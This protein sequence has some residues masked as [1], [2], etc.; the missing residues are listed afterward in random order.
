LVVATASFLLV[1]GPESVRLTSLWAR[2]LLSIVFGSFQ[3]LPLLHCMHDASHTS[4][5]PSSGWWRFLGRLTM[6]FF[7][8]ASLTSWQHQHIVGHHVYTNVLGADPDLPVQV[9]GDIRRVAPTQMWAP[10]Y[11]FQHLYL[12]FLYGVLAIKFRIQDITDTL[13]AKTNGPIRV[14]IDTTK[15]ALWVAGTKLFWA[16]WRIALPLYLWRVP[17]VEYWALFLIAEWTTGYYLTFNFQVSHISPALAF[18]DTEAASVR[19]SA[20]A[21]EWAVAQMKSTV[22]YAHGSWLAAFLCGALNYQ[23]V[24]HLFPC[25]SQYHYPALA[26]LVQ[27][28]AKKHGV[29]YHCLDSFAT[30]FTLH[31]QHLKNMGFHDAAAE[32]A[33]T[34]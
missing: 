4:I 12:L 17:S 13:I 26:P 30:A 11:R 14:N 34:H 1:V 16:L 5:G 18:P 28:V 27:K 2:V 24:H 15:E 23:V 8:G 7:A 32:I 6:D 31:V 25:V 9:R 21:D 22:D 10:L 20:F 3:A 33:A 29:P 19:R